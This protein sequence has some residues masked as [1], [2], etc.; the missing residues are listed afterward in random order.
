VTKPATKKPAV[1]AI[2][3]GDRRAT[4][5]TPWPLVQ[6]EPKRVPM[7]TSRPDTVG[8]AGAWSIWVGGEAPADV[9]AAGTQQAA[10]NP[11]DTGDAAVGHQQKRRPQADQDAAARRSQRG[12]VDPVDVHAMLRNRLVRMPAGGHAGHR[13][14]ADSIDRF[15]KQH[16]FDQN[17]NTRLTSSSN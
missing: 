16:G 15:S 6:P 1:A 3:C 11:A 10:D 8:R 2:E 4:P 5:H 12:E 14:R 9:A 13:Q 17:E 7:P